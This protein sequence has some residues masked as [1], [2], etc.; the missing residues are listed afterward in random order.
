MKEIWNERYAQSG[1]AYGDAPNVFLQM[2]LPKIE[3]G[4]I[5]FAAEGEGRNAVF[6]ATLG[7]EVS[8][9]DWSEDGKNKAMML[10]NQQ[11]V[12]LDYRVGE[13]AE[14]EYPQAHFDVVALIYAHFSADKKSEYHKILDTYVKKGGYVILEGFSKKNLDYVAQNPGIGGPKDIDMLFSVQEIQADFANYEVVLLEE[15]EVE[16]Q[17]GKYH[18]GKGSVVRFVGRKK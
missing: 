15:I 4:K 10:A 14:I 8:A 18:N 9:F 16:L 1:F 5:L 11:H 2:Q 3:T 17:E 13:F 12:S 6:A 7:W